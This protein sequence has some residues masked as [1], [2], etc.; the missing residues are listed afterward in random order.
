MSVHYKGR[1]RLR[2]PLA[3]PD[4]PQALEIVPSQARRQL[5]R[6]GQGSPSRPARSRAW[7]AAARRS[8][9]TSSNV[10]ADPRR[11]ARAEDRRRSTPGCTTG[12]SRRARRLPAARANAG[13]DR[14]LAG[15]SARAGAPVETTRKALTLLGGILQRALET[16]RIRGEPA[17]ARPQ[18]GAGAEATRCGRWRRPRSRR[19]GGAR[20]RPRRSRMLVSLLGLCWS[21]PAGAARCDVGRTSLSARSSSTPRRPGAIAPPRTVRLLAPLAQDLREWRLR[22]GRPGARPVDPARTTAASD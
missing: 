2:R 13:G 4:P 11:G 3:L 20:R 9:S 17:A 16:G 1:R 8:T 12:R 21:A 6:S 7:T 10:G 15:R 19:F 18:G 14:P 5:R 22:L